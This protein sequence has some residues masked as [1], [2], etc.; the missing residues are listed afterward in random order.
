MGITVHQYIYSLQFHLW[1]SICDS[2]RK[3]V[4]SPHKCICELEL[5]ALWPW[6]RPSLWTSAP[7]SLIWH[8]SQLQHAIEKWNPG[9]SLL[10]QWLRIHFVMQVMWAQSLVGELRSYMPGATKTMC[11][12]ERSS[13]TQQNIPCAIAKT[14]WSQ[15]FIHENPWLIHVN[16]WQ[17]P[18]QYCKVISLQLIK[19]NEKKIILNNNEK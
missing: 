18:L 10:V 3:S 4:T 15:I 7:I 2:Y 14:Q 17:K 19:I 11:H 8:L 13:M 9:T 1:K 5:K 16:V 12:K 6:A